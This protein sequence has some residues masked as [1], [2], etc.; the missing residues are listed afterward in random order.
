[1]V[2]ILLSALHSLVYQQ[3]HY[4]RYRSVDLGPDKIESILEHTHQLMAR[5]YHVIPYKIYSMK[6]NSEEEVVRGWAYRSS[7]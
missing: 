2:K 5:T 6:L 7:E 3:V 1:M 4:V